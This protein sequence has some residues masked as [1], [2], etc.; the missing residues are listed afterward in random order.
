LSIE[1]V[2]IAGIP[3]LW[4]PSQQLIRDRYISRQ[5][6]LLLEKYH[7]ICV[8]LKCHRKWEQEKMWGKNSH[9]MS[10]AGQ[11]PVEYQF[12]TGNR[13]SSKFSDKSISTVSMEDY[14]D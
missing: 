6:I 4:M 10:L 9:L 5:Q 1:K 7:K 14:T 8:I 2:G 13:L 3:S 11:T 12:F